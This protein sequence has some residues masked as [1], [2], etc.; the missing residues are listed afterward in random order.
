[1]S[2]GEPDADAARVVL[3][4]EPATERTFAAVSTPSFRRYLRRAHGGPTT[5]GD[6]WREFVNG[7]CGTG[8]EVELRV[9]AVEDGDRLGGR[10]ALEFGPR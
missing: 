2:D 6:V 4:I 7:G 3:A 5:A 10:T 8:T 1:M 9:T